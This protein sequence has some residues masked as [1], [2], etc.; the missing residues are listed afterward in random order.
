MGKG[1]VLPEGAAL[2]YE[3]QCGW[4][5]PYQQELSGKQGQKVGPGSR[6]PQNF[7]RKWVLVSGDQR[8]VHAVIRGDLGSP[9]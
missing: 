1:R 2:E 6:D 4:I 5:E 8:L 7:L 3:P 9:S